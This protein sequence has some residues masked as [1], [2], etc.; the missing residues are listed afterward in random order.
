MN[1]IHI[2]IN[3]NEVVIDGRRLGGTGA[4]GDL[5]LLKKKIEFLTASNTKFK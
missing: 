3:N 1:V 2:D 4:V 5:V